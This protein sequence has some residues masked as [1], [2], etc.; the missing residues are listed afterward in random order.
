MQKDHTAEASSPQLALALLYEQEPEILK[1]PVQAI[2]MAITGGIQ[3]KNQRLAFNAMLKHAIEE[4]GRDKSKH[5]DTYSIS[6]VELMRIINYTSPNRKYLKDT[7]T[8]M[9][10]LTV[11]W[12]F[13][14]QDG[15]SVWSSCV[16]LPFISFDRE[17]IYY[18]YAPQIKHLLL[19]PKIYAN[20]DLRIQRAFRLDSSA[21]LYEWVTR[22]RNVR[23]TNEMGWEEWRWVIYGEIGA[24]SVLHQYKIFKRDKLNPAIEE[25]NRTSDLT[26]T[27][28][29]NRDGGRRVKYLQFTVEEKEI[30]SPDDDM[31]DDPRAEWDRRLEEF[32]VSPKDRKKILASFSVADIEAAFKYTEVRLNDKTK[33]VLKSPVRYLIRAL[34]GKYAPEAPPAGAAGRPPKD[35]HHAMSNIQESFTRRRNDDAQAMFAEMLHADREREI[36]HYNAQVSSESALVPV[37]Q[38]ARLAR[39]MIPFYSWLAK[40]TWG[41]PTPQEI[42]DFAVSTGA[43]SYNP[44]KMP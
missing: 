21:A 32:K 26:I 1:K 3:N 42:F 7:L 36:E 35:S 22:F 13:L 28:R 23:Y 38:D 29:E 20:L 18:S 14:K 4:H 41:E 30:F 44:Q 37:L 16:L 9:Q 34:E 24:T 27:L 5:V 15:D 6:R 39:H 10:K 12:D 2:H 40:K 19:E 8:A 43:I 11:Q 25:I 33:P 31:A 17:N